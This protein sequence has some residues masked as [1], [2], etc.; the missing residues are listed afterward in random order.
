M[1]NHSCKPNPRGTG[2]PQ[3]NSNQ[4]A[5]E[6]VN[7]SLK[8][9]WPRKCSLGLYMQYVCINILEGSAASKFLYVCTQQRSLG[10]SDRKAQSTLNYYNRHLNGLKARQLHLLYIQ[11]AAFS[12]YS[13]SIAESRIKSYF[14]KHFKQ[15]IK[16]REEWF[17][18]LLSIRH[19]PVWDQGS[20]TFYLFPTPRFQLHQNHHQHISN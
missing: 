16:A 11:L 2:L 13:L 15:N 1:L 5:N 12:L 6:S 10:K 3:T 18:K 19:A 7:H 17:F 9:V 8:C 4:L 14:F 20:K